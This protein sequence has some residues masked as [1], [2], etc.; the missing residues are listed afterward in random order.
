[1][2]VEGKVHLISVE[3]ARD[4]LILM[5]SN[6]FSASTQKDQRDAEANVIGLLN[7]SLAD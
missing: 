4:E 6:V 1:M 3:L 2:E 7:A 5:I